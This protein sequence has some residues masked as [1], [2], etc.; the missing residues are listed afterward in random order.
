[1]NKFLLLTLFILISA[2]GTFILPSCKPVEEE[3]QNTG[4][5]EFS[6]D[7]VKFDTVFTT[8]STI[9]KRLWIYNR[10]RRG[11]NVELIGLANPVSSPYT[12]IINGDLKQTANNIFIRGQ[13]SLLI[14]VRA[15]LPDNGQ[16]GIAKDYVLQENINFQTNGNSQ[17]VLLRSFGQNIYLHDG[18]TLPCGAIWKNDRPHVLYGTVTVP[19]NCTLTIKPGTRV[20]AHAGAALLVEGT[21]LANSPV[22]FHPGTGLTDTVKATSPN[23]VRFSGDRTEV[24]YVTAPGQW[25]GIISTQVAMVTLFA[26]PKFRTAHSAC[27]CTTQIT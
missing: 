7:T 12:L 8:L 27:Y 26:I 6:A 17:H 23:I 2:I 24:Q 13:D 16:S 18:T 25:R 14:L 20:Y 11:V 15:N 1:M 21:L 19:V 4:G 9:T 3:L 22:D 5:L 10:N